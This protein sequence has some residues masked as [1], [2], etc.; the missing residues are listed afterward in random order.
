MAE[1][2][3]TVSLEEQHRVR[4]VLNMLVEDTGSLRSS[5]VQ[6]CCCSLEPAVRREV[7]CITMGRL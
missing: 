4:G 6:R 5:W 3:D 7:A 2:L 1:A